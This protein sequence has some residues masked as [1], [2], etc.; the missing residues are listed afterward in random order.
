MTSGQEDAQFHMLAYLNLSQN[1]SPCTALGFHGVI[2]P[3]G[4][5]TEPGVGDLERAL[6]M[7]LTHCFSS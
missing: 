2:M 6:L 1:A 5:R 3:D 7:T 4:M